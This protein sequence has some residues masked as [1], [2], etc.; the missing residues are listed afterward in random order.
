M[1]EWHFLRE[2]YSELVARERYGGA[3]DVYIHGNFANLV[4][5]DVD[6]QIIP[7]TAA[8]VIEHRD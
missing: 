8:G 7:K 4:I 6:Q 2:I 1:H 3:F 5:F